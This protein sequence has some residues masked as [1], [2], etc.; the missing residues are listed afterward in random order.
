MGYLLAISLGPVQGFIAAAR[1]TRDLWYGSYMLSETSRHAA[2]ALRDAGVELVFPAPA[3]LGQAP[4][5]S[6]APP[7][8]NRIIAVV[9]DGG[10]PA[11]LTEK[12]RS[13]A[14]DYL[15]QQ[16]D[17]ALKKVHRENLIDRVLLER[18]LDQLLELYAAWW[19]YDGTDDGYATARKEVDGLLAGRKALRDFPPAPLPDA[20]RT[21]VCMSALDGGRASVLRSADTPTL[22]KLGVKSGEYLDGVSLVK[23]L[24][25][26]RHFVSVSR[27]A[28]DPL[29]RRLRG[30]TRFD[31]LKRLAGALAGT[32][33]VEAISTDQ[34]DLAQFAHFPFDS[35]LLAAGSAIDR[36]LD[37]V[38]L[39]EEQRQA[40]RRF[41]ELF[42]DMCRR[43]GVAE[44]PSYLAVLVADGDRVGQLISTLATRE[45]H[46]RFSEAG[47]RF[48]RGARTVVADHY[49]ALVY[50]GG[51]DVLALLPLDTAIA[52]AAK[53]NALFHQT[54]TEAAPGVD[55]PTLSVGIS[56]GHCYE[57]LRNLLAWGRQ[58]ESTAKRTRD[59]LAV[60]LHTRSA[61]ATVVTAARSWQDDP[62]ARWRHWIDW[63]HEDVLP[64]GAAY[65]LRALAREL[66]GLARAGS[67][68]ETLVDA[69]CR[70]I[71]KRKKGR[72]GTRELTGAEI[73]M[74]LV[75]PR[76]Q[77]SKDIDAT[78]T[79]LERLEGIV[80]E[81]IIARHLARAG[82]PSGHAVGDEAGPAHAR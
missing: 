51:D 56:I 13:A 27:I 4:D 67:D 50:S 60:A 34:N 26:G 71:L 63:F 11:A 77:A 65:E 17:L 38:D 7:V 76:P 16:R 74:V 42:R 72:R 53:L 39:P 58:A 43:A 47:T 1:K 80:D 18:Q 52:C 48:A 45:E 64:D 55:P 66:R 40:A 5:D 3:S 19:P 20:A 70:R 37:E 21:W 6:E 32:E 59:T 57:N 73:E 62:L 10:D 25:H 54:M 9:A 35:D 82:N 41:T 28:A 24:A 69:E 36:M 81:M 22:A 61:G 79:G 33:L 78:Q 2:M 68:V 12:A 8:A 29:L 44:P 14:R 75:W 46:R 30:D 49:G 23:R 31:E 15:S